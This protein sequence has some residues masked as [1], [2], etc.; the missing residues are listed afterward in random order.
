MA[1]KDA[2]ILTPDTYEHVAFHGK[3]DFVDVVKK[4]EMGPF[5]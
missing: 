3:R 4:L 2:H 5:I 1:P